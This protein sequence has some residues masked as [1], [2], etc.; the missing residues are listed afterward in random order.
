MEGAGGAAGGHAPEKRRRKRTE[1]E[2][3]ERRRRKEAEAAGA[4]GG[5][6]AP[7]VFQVVSRPTSAVS[8]AS[9]VSSVNNVV[10][11]HNA[12][13]P[14]SSG[15]AAQHELPGGL[16]SRGGLTTAASGAPVL[17]T[18]WGSST[19]PPR[20]AH[21]GDLERASFIAPD[22]RQVPEFIPPSYAVALKA[23]AVQL[24][25]SM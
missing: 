5:H 25:H 12:S 16:D 15:D 20:P 24:L 1:A 10:H 9:A 17:S 4:A 19:P 14:P 18:A 23:G 6:E 3:E 13:H 11:A 7:E 8:N 21:V 2:K 22:G